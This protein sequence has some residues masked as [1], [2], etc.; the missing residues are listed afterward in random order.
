MALERVAVLLGAGAS[1]DADLPMTG[2][3]TTALI[4]SIKE[5]FESP[6]PELVE[7][8]NFV[9]S[10]MIG[11]RGNAGVDPYSALN[12][13][14]VFSAIRLLQDR[15][16]HEAA[17]FVSA[18]LPSVESFDNHPVPSSDPYVPNHTMSGFADGHQFTTTIAKIARAAMKPGNGDIYRELDAALKTQVCKLLAGHKN[19]DYLK[20]LADLALEQGGLTVATLNYDLTVESM[21]QEV[22]VD[23]DT[24][25]LN[26]TPGKALTFSQAPKASL[27]L[28]KLHGSI[29]W[30][31]NPKIP[32][33]DDTSRFI[34][35]Q[36]LT[37]TDPSDNRQPAIIIGDRE[38]LT[39]DGPTLALM[40]SFEESLLKAKRLV[41]IGYSFGD[42]HINSVIRNWINA[43]SERTLT[44]LD[45]YWTWDATGFQKDLINGLTDSPLGGPTGKPRMNVITKKTQE[46]LAEALRLRPKAAPPTQLRATFRLDKYR[47]PMIRITNAGP[48]ITQLKISA[49]RN[50]PQGRTEIIRGFIRP[51]SGAGAYAT[52]VYDLHDLDKGGQID[53]EPVF[54]PQAEHGRT[55]VDLEYLTHTGR[56]SARLEVQV[57]SA[58]II[59]AAPSA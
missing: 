31:S 44:V 38:K 28:I 9:C 5:E 36:T 59:K 26:W 47:N 33:M 3:L 34:R 51:R 15:A 30:T 40:H 48:D 58:G 7:A 25:I 56:R 32:G 17:P 11:H 50:Q 41:V 20:P 39:A 4:K 16:D 35:T 6:R 29:N 46:G 52:H 53:V 21:C 14:R 22:G 54:L 24:G 42:D 19:V 13:E 49:V 37:E 18:W 23:I 10:A 12:V 57:T 55:A 27:N 2:G 1:V 8:F 43:R 45:P